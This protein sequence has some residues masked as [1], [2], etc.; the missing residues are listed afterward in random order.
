VIHRTTLPFFH[1]GLRLVG[2][3]F[4]NTDRLDARQPGVIVTGSWLT[5]KE[6]MPELYATRLAERG[7]AAFTFDFAGFGESDGDPRQAEIPDRK[8]ADLMAAAD[9][10]STLS[11]VEPDSLTH[12]AICASAQYGLAALAR[13][14]RVAR[15]VSVA[16]WYHDIVSVAPFYGG[17]SGVA[18]RLDAARVAIERHASSGTIDM[19]PAYKAGDPAAG[20]F[21]ELDYYGNTTRGAVPAWKNQMATMSWWYWLT[22]DGLRAADRVSTPTLLVHGDGCVLPENARSVHSRLRGPKH[23]VWVEG[24]QTDF[25]DQPAQVELAVN[26]ADVF[27]KGVA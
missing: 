22:F 25:Y 9:Y 6:Q 16:G 1:G 3:L 19:V 18:A 23:L 13:G 8:V 12:L 15:F 14:S 26:A 5:V 11:F 21:F 7:Y 10:L 2:R 27:L 20:M 24:G 17:L 4:R